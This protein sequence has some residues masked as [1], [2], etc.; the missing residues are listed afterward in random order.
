MGWK[1]RRRPRRRRP[2]P[3]PRGTWIAHRRAGVVR[4]AELVRDASELGATGRGPPDGLEL[5]DG[6][7]D[8]LE[9][10]R[11]DRRHRARVADQNSSAPS[12]V[13]QVTGCRS[14]PRRMSTTVAQHEPAPAVLVVFEQPSH[15]DGPAPQVG[16]RFERRSSSED[17]ATA[18]T[19]AAARRGPVRPTRIRG[20]EHRSGPV[21]RLAAGQHDQHLGWRRG[22]GR[23]D[24]RLDV[25]SAPRVD[26]VR[27]VDVDGSDGHR[28]RRRRREAGPATGDRPLLDEHREQH[29]AGHHRESSVHAAR[30]VTCVSCGQCDRGGAGSGSTPT[31]SARPGSFVRERHARCGDRSVVERATDD[32]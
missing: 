19:Q 25:V 13:G 18:V 29:A 27:V 5:V 24:V 30:Q 12:S 15:G 14:I 8:A 9:P 4:P 21:G 22:D 32:R 7:D 2:A 1:L 20:E 17:G 28:S 26:V 31:R 3:A 16:A 11:R 10:R 23:S 6:V